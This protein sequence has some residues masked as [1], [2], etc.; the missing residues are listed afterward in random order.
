MDQIVHT[1]IPSALVMML[2][3]I[4]N[5]LRQGLDFQALQAVAQSLKGKIYCKLNLR[6]G[7]I[8][9]G[10]QEILEVAMQRKMDIVLFLE[11][12]FKDNT[13][14]R[15]I[16]SH[17]PSSPNLIQGEVQVSLEHRR[18][19]LFVMIRHAK[20]LSCPA[21]EHLNS[22]VKL[23]YRR[24]PLDLIRTRKLHVTIWHDDRLQEK[25][26]LGCVYIPLEDI[27]DK[28]ETTN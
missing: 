10:R 6:R 13:L 20:N 5:L 16:K 23:E 3:M 8:N 1:R 4:V 28:R 15:K 9:I 19:T 24:Y 7:V 11:S 14:S 22:Y 12:V 21:I 17:G 2:L 26:F 18:N 25:K 27:E